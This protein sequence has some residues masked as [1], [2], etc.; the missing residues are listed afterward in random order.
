MTHHHAAYLRDTAALIKER[1]EAAILATG[2]EP[3]AY[4]GLGWSD[5]HGLTHTVRSK[6]DAHVCEVDIEENAEHIA[7]WS[8]TAALA[9]ADLLAG[10]ADYIDAR[11]N[12]YELPGTETPNDAGFIALPL[13]FARACRGES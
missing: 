13:A 12:G 6:A 9:A 11:D 3:W 4:T 5:P 1:A 10:V 2:S 8:P 7:G